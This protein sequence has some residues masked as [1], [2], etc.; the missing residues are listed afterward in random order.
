MAR[1]TDP[2]LS[3]TDQMQT[4]YPRKPYLL[5]L[6]DPANDLNDLGK[7]TYAIKHI[8]AVFRR[9]KQRIQFDLQYENRYQE[10]K[11][12]ERTW[13]YMEYLVKADYRWFELHRSRVERCADPTKLDD[14]DFSEGRIAREFENRVSWYKGVAEEHDKL[15]MKKAIATQKPEQSLELHGINDDEYGWQLSPSTDQR[16]LLEAENRG[17]IFQKPPFG[18][19]FAEALNRTCWPETSRKSQEGQQ[20]I[21]ASKTRSKPPKKD[22]NHLAQKIQVNNGNDGRSLAR[23]K[24]SEKHAG[25][26]ETAPTRPGT[27]H[28]D[29]VEE[30][31]RG[32]ASGQGPLGK[33]GVLS[34]E[35]EVHENDA[36]KGNAGCDDEAREKKVS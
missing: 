13:S 27:Q 7:M 28:E 23:M 33:E 26:E 2:Q 32:E 18:I 19:A 10:D 34:G 35:E 6:Q 22:P 36:H 4:L 24:A 1:L 9:A 14:R 29:L 15:A 21:P 31:D 8:Q 25:V 3:R 5:C 20:I 30:R 12:E 16:P 11:S 17:E